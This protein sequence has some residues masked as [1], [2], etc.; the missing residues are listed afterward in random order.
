MTSNKVAALALAGSLNTGSVISVYALSEKDRGGL[1]G[2]IGEALDPSK[3][4]AK[5]TLDG[6]EYSDKNRSAK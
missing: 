5:R 2:R 4:M 3:P 1:G 6:A